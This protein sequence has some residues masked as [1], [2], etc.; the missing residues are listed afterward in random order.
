MTSPQFS[1]TPPWFEA[2]LYE[3]ARARRSLSNE[4]AA[5]VDDYHRDG[6]ARIDFGFDEALLVEAAAQT[7]ALFGE[8]ARAQD[9]WRQSAAVRDLAAAPQV[10]SLLS[11]LYERRA[12]PFQTLN[13]PA[14]SEQ[15]THSDTYHFNSFP[16]R[17][18]CG[19]W[20]ALEDVDEGNGPLHYYPGSHK[21]PVVSVDDVGSLKYSDY[22]D[23]VARLIARHEFRK[24]LGILR[25]GEAILWSANLL[26]GGEPIREAGRTRLSQ[27]N[28]YYF[29]GCAYF[30]P[31]NAQDGGPFLRAPFD[32]ARGRYV[33]NTVFGRP[34]F[35][36]FRT[37]LS[38]FMSNALKRAPS[39]PDKRKH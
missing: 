24:E 9:L 7:K 39:V 28:H 10:L 4:V 30:T 15:R 18:M 31:L 29:D 26:H 16:P 3:E 12:F 38:A 20:I 17:F 27:V 33:S 32:I 11:E 2:P 35:P 19:L 5:I 34:I 14:G 1:F 8:T 21:L 25:R 13:F 22:E 6:Y 36:K 23:Y 37:A